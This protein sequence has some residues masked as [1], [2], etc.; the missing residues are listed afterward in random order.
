MPTTLRGF[1]IVPFDMHSSLVA[2]DPT[3]YTNPR[4]DAL[5]LVDI[6]VL[7]HIVIGGECAISL[8]ERGLI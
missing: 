4:K 1:T 2:H 6:R 7:D 5:A 3:T 8:A